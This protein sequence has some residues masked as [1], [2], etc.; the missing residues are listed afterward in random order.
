MVVIRLQGGL[1]LASA[2]PFAGEMGSAEVA[3]SPALVIDL[4]STSFRLVV[5]RAGASGGRRTDEIYEPVRIGAGLAASGRLG[6]AP[7][8]GALATMDVF[9]H[10]CAASGLEAPAID[11]V[12][13]S[14]IRDAANGQE[15][16]ALAHARTGLPV[17]LLDG[18]A[19]ARYGYLAAVNSTTLSEGMA[20]DLGGGSLQLVAVSGRAE[21]ESASW[22]LGTVRMSEGF[23]PGSGP[24]K[25]GQL[26]RRG[27][28][29]GG[30]ARGCFRRA[31]A[32]GPRPAAVRG[33]APRERAEPGRPVSGRPR[34]HAPRRGARPGHVRRAGTARAARRRRPRARALVG[35]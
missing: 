7:V 17:R 20:L 5:F 16:L 29:G 34:P 11:A 12:A 9:A 31:P 28:G 8:G 3:S 1:D 30:R 24:A 19:E 33:R 14:A 32:G 10:F 21:R 13:T 35:G 6:D 26:R 15:F 23:L 25:P 4:G 18:R 22:P 27:G 2:P